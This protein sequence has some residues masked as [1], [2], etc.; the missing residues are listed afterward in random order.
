MTKIINLKS[1]D[2]KSKKDKDSERGRSSVKKDRGTSSSQKDIKGTGRDSKKNDKKARKRMLRSKK[3][4]LPVA[5]ATGSSLKSD[6]KTEI[7]R[8]TRRTTS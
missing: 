1:S 4:V 7:Y 8:Q 5:V 2:A 6:Q 3:L